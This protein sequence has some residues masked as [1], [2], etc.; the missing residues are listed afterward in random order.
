V[1]EQICQVIK[2]KAKKC[3]DHGVS[4]SAYKFKQQ[5]VEDGI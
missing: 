5:A 2:E 3:T 4:S 1:K